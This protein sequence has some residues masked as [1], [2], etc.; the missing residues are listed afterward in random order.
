MVNINPDNMIEVVLNGVTFTFSEAQS[1]ERVKY[2]GNYDDCFPDGY[3]RQWDKYQ[4]IHDTFTQ[5]IEISNYGHLKINKS[6][7]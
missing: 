7:R 6:R 1:S 5:E 4:L 2:I 3:D